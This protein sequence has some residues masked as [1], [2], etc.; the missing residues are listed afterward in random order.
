MPLTREAL[1]VLSVIPEQHNAFVEIDTDIHLCIG[2]PQCTEISGET[3]EDMRDTWNKPH[4]AV[5]VDLQSCK[6]HLKQVATDTASVRCNCVL[7]KAV[8]ASEK[9]AVV[10]AS[11]LG[12]I[13]YDDLIPQYKL[14]TCDKYTELNITGVLHIKHDA[15]QRHVEP[16]GLLLAYKLANR[17]IAVLFARENKRKRG[18]T[19]E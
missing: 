9:K 16:D 13:D 1:D 17:E 10:L 12:I 6:V 11:K 19:S 8:T 3:I 5:S 18:Y 15:I 2:L 4:S 7:P 14:L